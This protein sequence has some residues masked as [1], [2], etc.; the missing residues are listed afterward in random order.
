MSAAAQTLLG[1]LAEK[2][3]SKTLQQLATDDAQPDFLQTEWDEPMSMLLSTELSMLADLG[4]D[5]KV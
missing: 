2:S 3:P 4:I 1:T 5:Y